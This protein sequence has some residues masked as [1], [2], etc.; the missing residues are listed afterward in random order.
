LLLIEESLELGLVFFI[1]SMLVLELDFAV[2]D[3][4]L[5]VHELVESVKHIR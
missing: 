5:H 1:G 3:F 2:L 4:R